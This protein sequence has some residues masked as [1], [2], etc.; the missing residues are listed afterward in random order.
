MIFLAADF[1]SSMVRFD[2][3]VD[4]FLRYYAYYIPQML[5][6]MIPVGCLIGTLF[7]LSNMNKS[8]ELVSLF[9]MGVSLA[10][11]SAPILVL[12]GVISVISF[13]LGD[14]LLPEAL[15]NKNYVYLVEM[16]KRPNLY[17]T[18]KQNKIWYRSN[19]VIFN[20]GVL[21]PDTSKAQALTM[22]Y[23]NEAWDLVQLIK[24][25][26]VKL[27]GD[28]WVLENGTV[29]LFSAESSFPMTREF[30][31][32]TVT[33]SEDLSDIKSAPPTS[34]VLTV[35][36]LRRYIRKNKALSLDTKRFEVDLHGKV[37]FAFSGFVL[38]LLGIPFTTRSQRSGGVMI[39][40]GVCAGLALVY[41][42]LFSAGLSVGKHGGLPPFLA[43]WGANLLLFIGAIY[44]LRRTY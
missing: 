38:A 3:G 8:N 43:A 25:Q 35:N 24:A 36:E 32:K 15:K 12:V 30:R 6:Q 31:Q 13:F 1:T 4:V 16:K 37:A 20:I 40:V 2:V 19:N 28:T 23:F 27:L 18:V 9:S 44:A 21:D 17:S 42:I 29:T 39:N 10:R 41:W 11:V 22:Y 33:M 34:D 5:Y 14:R 26:T 7:T